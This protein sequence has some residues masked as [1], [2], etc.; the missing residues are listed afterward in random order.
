MIHAG[1]STCH[2]EILLPDLTQHVF[3]IDHDSAELAALFDGR[4]EAAKRVA[5]PLRH[6]VPISADSKRSSS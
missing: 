2:D 5:P 1:C 3:G 6:S 4:N